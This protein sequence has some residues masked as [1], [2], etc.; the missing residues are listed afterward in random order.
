MPPRKKKAEAEPGLAI[1]VDGTEHF[2]CLSDLTAIDAKDFR[3]QVGV[4]LQAVFAGAVGTD[5]DIIAGLVWLDRRRTDQRLQ[6]VTVASE[7]TFRTPFS[8]AF[9]DAEEAETDPEV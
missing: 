8:V 5:I 4:P 1:T 9:K 6:Y 3:A 7:M 2:I